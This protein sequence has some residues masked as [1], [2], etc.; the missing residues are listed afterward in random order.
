M[1][2]E[3]LLPPEFADLEPFARNW[4]LPSENERQARR[5]A[6]TFA[7]LEAL[8]DA[9][10]PRAPE[11]IAY[12]DRLDIDDLPEPA[13]RLMHLL[14]SLITI[15]YAVDVFRQPSIPDSGS[16]YFDVV[17]EPVP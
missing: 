8:Y 9:V 17:S 16:A 1:T 12:L 5:L 11:A 10:A 6:S 3:A 7:E 14:C 15:S 13:R 2:T 4:S